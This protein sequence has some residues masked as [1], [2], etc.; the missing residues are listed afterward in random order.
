M[1]Q[2]FKGSRQKEKGEGGLSTSLSQKGEATVLYYSIIVHNSGK[3]EKLVTFEW[4]RP[5]FS[6]QVSSERLF[7]TFYLQMKYLS[8][9]QL[10]SEEK[11]CIPFSSHLLSGGKVELFVCTVRCH[12]DCI[13][14]ALLLL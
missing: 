14:I 2:P 4:K 8:K 11:I 12:C 10:S 3:K 7:T 13:R 1:G 6:E 9:V 5:P